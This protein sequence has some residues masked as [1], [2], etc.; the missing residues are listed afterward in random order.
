MALTLW[1]FEP[2]QTP[3]LSLR[4][5]CI[6]S[7]LIL[8]L[9]LCGRRNEMARTLEDVLARRTRTLFLNAAAA[10]AMAPQVAH[11][12]AMELKRDQT[13]ARRQ[14]ESFASLAAQYLPT[15]VAAQKGQR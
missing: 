1:R 10:I 2:W 7:C 14:A 11:I 15:M 13:W 4:G 9:R 8:S 5:S 12:L 6:R 3:S